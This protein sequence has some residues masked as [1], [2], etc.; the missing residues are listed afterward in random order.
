MFIEINICKELKYVYMEKEQFVD[1][2]NQYI[3]RT[4]EANI[5]HLTCLDEV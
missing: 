4:M 3:T 1:L 2:K 5:F